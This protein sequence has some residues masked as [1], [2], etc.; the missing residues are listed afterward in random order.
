M[1][2]RL[3]REYFVTLHPKYAS[4]L[5]VQRSKGQYRTGDEDLDRILSHPA[6]ESFE[7]VFKNPKLESEAGVSLAP[8]YTVR[9]EK[10]VPDRVKAGLEK[11]F[12]KHRG[13]RLVG[14]SPRLQDDMIPNDTL[15]DYDGNGEA[16]F[17]D[18]T[19]AASYLND[20]KLR[21]QWNM[22]MIGMPEAWD[23][24][25][26]KGVTIGIVDTG[27]DVDHPDLAANI[28]RDGGGSVMGDSDVRGN[29][30]T[31][32]AGLAAAVGNNGEGICGVAFEAKIVAVACEPA[33]GN[34]DEGMSNRIDG[35][36]TCVDLG[37]KVI[38]CSWSGQ[39]VAYF[40][41]EPFLE[42]MK[43]ALAYATALDRV[44]VCSA[45]NEP[46]DLSDS[47]PYTC[48]PAALNGEVFDGVEIV[49]IPVGAVDYTASRQD[50]SNYGSWLSVCAPGDE[51]PSTDR[52]DTATEFFGYNYSGSFR[53][54][55][56]FGNTSAAAPQVAGV[57]ALM[58]EMCPGLKPR[59]I[60]TGIENTATKIG[61]VEY[62][63]ETGRHP[64]YGHGLVNAPGAVTFAAMYCCLAE[65]LLKLCKE[66]EDYY[67]TALR[68]VRDDFLVK[69]PKG[70]TLVR[71]YYRFSP[72]IIQLLQAH[73]KLS[74]SLANRLRSLLPSTALLL[75]KI[76]NAKS[77]ALNRR[78]LITNEVQETIESMIRD[79]EEAGSSPALR[80]ALKEVRKELKAVAGISRA[81]FL[82][83]YGVELKP[84]VDIRL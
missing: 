19:L 59:Q 44:V 81:E 80:Q 51:S 12:R 29:H 64:R 8:Y 66:L 32:V 3:P 27:V 45:G 43:A 77:V 30:G 61:G 20:W 84:E 46:L 9:F 34:L 39:S 56:P 37:A 17:D 68:Q 4:G 57:C 41:I 7:R 15:Y 25:T 26:G 33:N 38:N 55:T 13:V 62:D 42:T 16:N 5:R 11:D 53:D 54:Y 74:R 71:K 70:R 52:H 78:V 40:D 36:T 67:Q 72:E 73:P 69:S 76:G 1:P 23:M 48:Y 58:L 21:E 35:I 82:K 47:I 31:P 6:I 60:R 63:E 28:L 65:Y 24:A 2:R 83:R 50:N 22:Q 18:T 49:L 10:M 14:P 75:G 79:V